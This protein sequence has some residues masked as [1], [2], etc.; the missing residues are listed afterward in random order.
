MLARRRWQQSVRIGGR[1]GSDAQDSHA[2][3]A[4]EVM[5]DAR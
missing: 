1:T 4:V 5:K 3:W 2:A